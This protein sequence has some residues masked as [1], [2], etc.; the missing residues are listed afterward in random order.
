MANIRSAKKRIRQTERRTEVNRRRLSRV[1]T[2]V[3]KVERAIA[4]GDKDGAVAAMRDA[5]PEIA[6]GAQQG[7]YHRNR[8]ARKVSRLTDAIS[9]LGG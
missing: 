6:R 4:A 7:L 5:E 9:K 2:F 3:K 8:A 1:R